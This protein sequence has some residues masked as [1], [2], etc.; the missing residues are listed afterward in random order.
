MKPPA[1][2][3]VFTLAAALTFGSLA[4]AQPASR[5]DAAG[6]GAPPSVA[7]LRVAA[8]QLRS[9][10]DLAANVAAI[11]KHLADCAARK[12]QIVAFPECAVSSY[13]T[14][15]ILKL[16]AEE[17][18]AAENAIAQA[19]GAHRIA[20]VVGIPERRGEQRLNC[21]LII[22]SGG[23][24][25]GRYYK[26][27]LVGQDI[28][29]KCS[30]GSEAPPVFMVGGVAA[31]V[32]ICHDSRYPELCRL[33]V[34]AGARVVFYISH[35]STISKENKMVPYRA[36]VQARAVENRIFMVHANAPADEIRKGSHGQSRIVAPDGNIIQEAS[37]LEEEVLVAD[38]DLAQATAETALK[39]LQGP[40][41][42]WWREGVK[43]VPIIK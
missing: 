28:A 8:V 18:V 40:L 37:Q 34:L 31:S 35:E 14:D 15:P 33:P 30:P 20:A 32:I 17:L 2:L 19:C 11:K 42:D 38:L 25:I 12:V 7:S 29:W 10:S 39:S 27:Q 43:R 16:S 24:I 22:D 21:A 26:A 6:S 41:A 36:Q 1:C 23:K 4:S 9:G 13:F 5:S 3:F